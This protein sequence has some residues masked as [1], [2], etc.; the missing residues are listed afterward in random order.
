MYL[1][2]FKKKIT[3]K[4]NV[5]KYNLRMW[6]AMWETCGGN[7]NFYCNLKNFP[8]RVLSLINNIMQQSFATIMNPF[9]LN[10]T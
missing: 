5:G 1:L 3:W 4:W 8:V 9:A 7:L 10:L 2:L 6:I